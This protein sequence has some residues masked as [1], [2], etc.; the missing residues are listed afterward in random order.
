MN[1][2]TVLIPLGPRPVYRQYIKEAIDS[3][4]NQNYPVDEILIIDDGADI[5]D[6]EMHEWFSNVEDFQWS[7]GIAKYEDYWYNK[8]R[9]LTITVWHSPTNLGFTSAFNI[10]M[11]VAKNDL[12]MYLAADDTLGVDAVKDAIEAYEAN[13][14]KDAWYSLTYES[15]DGISDIPINAACITK[16]LWAWLKGYPTAAFMGPDA[17]M[18]SILLT[19]APDRI[20]KVAPGKVN[21]KIKT[22]QWQETKQQ[23]GFY[24]P[25]GIVE[26]IR[27]KETERFVPN[28]EIILK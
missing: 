27:N 23:I 5:T 1:K 11:A 24:E 9:S 10:G 19:Y 26:I 6:Q 25:T 18:L 28:T 8:T 14:Q 13:I 16:P 17:V 2:V 3:V 22:H 7:G 20:I 15:A 4:L 21:Y 12:V